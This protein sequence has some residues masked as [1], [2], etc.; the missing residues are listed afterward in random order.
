MAKCTST[1]VI[2][3]LTGAELGD[4]AVTV[5]FALE[6]ASYEIDLAPA[7]AADLREALEPFIGAARKVGRASRGRGT[8]ASSAPTGE[9]S[10]ARAWLVEQGADVP[11]RGRLSADLLERYRAR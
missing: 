7:S 9:Q 3:D 1:I 4:D 8:A 11:S 2:D 6:G 5:T 10:A